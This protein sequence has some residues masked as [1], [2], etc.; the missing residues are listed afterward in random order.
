MAKGLVCG[1]MVNILGPITHQEVRGDV[2]SDSVG[3]VE[4]LSA[5]MDG[6]AI[7]PLQIYSIVL[8]ESKAFHYEESNG[9]TPIISMTTGADNDN[10]NDVEALKVVK[11]Y[12]EEWAR[13][14]EL[15]RNEWDALQKTNRVSKNGQRI[16]ST[17]ND[18]RPSVRLSS[19]EAGLL[20]YSPCLPV[21]LLAQQLQKRSLSAPRDAVHNDTLG[22]NRAESLHVA[23]R[24]LLSVDKLFC[25]SVFFGVPL[26]DRTRTLRGPIRIHY[27]ADPPPTHDEAVAYQAGRTDAVEALRTSMHRRA[28]SL[29]TTAL[30]NQ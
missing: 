28:K 15:L 13:R 26:L 11:Y 6:L 7:W 24:V 10:D 12:G 14:D 19:N 18:N 16:G 5:E 21:L 29:L 22:C 9:T 20:T 1:P 30:S 17:T 4:G 23:A 27:V 8:K 2:L 3:S 25:L